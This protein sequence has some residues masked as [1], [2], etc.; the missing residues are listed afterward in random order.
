LASEAF[1]STTKSG[2]FHAVVQSVTGANSSS[3]AKPV[4]V[5]RE[6][7]MVFSPS[8]GAPNE[9]NEAQLSDEKVGSGK[10]TTAT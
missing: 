5:S 7:F 8:L 2:A 9:R 4:P 3:H 1:A 6:N 10:P